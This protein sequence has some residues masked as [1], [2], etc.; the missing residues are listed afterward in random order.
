MQL[1]LLAKIGEV[2][3]F[4][5]GEVV[6]REGDPGREMFI[7]LSGS[8]RVQRRSRQGP[9]TIATLGPGSFFGEMSLLEKLA[10]SATVVAEEPLALIAIGEGQF[11]AALSAEPQLAVRMMKVLSSRIR[12]LEE[13]LLTGRPLEAP[14]QPAAG[15]P[16]EAA[17]PEAERAAHPE[18]VEEQSPQAPGAGGTGTAFPES[19]PDAIVPGFAD[20]EYLY[21]KTIHCPVCQGKFEAYH[22]RA[23]RLRML[24]MDRDLRTRY[25]GFEPLWFQVWVCPHCRY[26]NLRSD[27]EAVDA[28]A[29]QALEAQRAERM[30]QSLRVNPAGGSPQTLGQAVDG[31]RLALMCAQAARLPAERV[32]RLWMYLAWMQADLK[33]LE[34]SRQARLRALEVLQEAY[35]H[36]HKAGEGQ[37]LAYLVGVL[38]Y[39]AG[40]LR[41]AYEYLQRAI[42]R[43]GGL[44]WIN[45][46]AGE[47]IGELRA[48]AR[49][50][51]ESAIPTPQAE[52]PAPPHD[53]AADA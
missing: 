41:E 40:H 50:G 44:H 14:A 23:G 16:E 37:R 4:R 52:Q 10:R 15:A 42:D 21:A 11:L 47:L 39:E 31:V 5:A 51:G 29:R 22:L 8:V 45:D 20:R 7:V 30:R 36:S 13:A 33:D 28:R 3:H 35:E 53:G 43:R 6:F 2:R 26:A 17:R 46:R 24:T 48:A 27:F 9:V 19:P 18:T 1:H 25:D 49:A 38:H 12:R 34:A 32:G